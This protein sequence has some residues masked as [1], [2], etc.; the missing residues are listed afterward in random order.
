MQKW[1][2]MKLLLLADQNSKNYIDAVVS[3][4]E[5]AVLEAKSP[6]EVDGVILCGGADVDPK[7]YGQPLDGSRDIDEARDKKEIAIVRE[8]IAKRIPILGICRGHQLLNV[9]LGGTLIQ[10]L[11]NAPS[12]MRAVPERDNT[13]G[14]LAVPD[15]IF[16]QLYG[17]RF[18]VNTSH[19]QAIDRLGEGL[20]AQVFAQDGTIE[21]CVHESLPFLSVQWHPE[22]MMPPH[23]EGEMADGA[24]IFKRFFQMIEN[25]NNKEKD[26]ES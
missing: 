6:D 20:V 23:R 10:H 4:G 24:L 16:S 7:Y 5:K 9:V 22:R 8:C 11:S 18:V 26:F 3:L 14:A 17:E 1:D 21:G 12:H 19:H 2:S 25:Y 13:H 15:S